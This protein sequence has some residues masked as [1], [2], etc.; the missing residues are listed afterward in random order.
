M[1]TWRMANEHSQTQEALRWIARWRCM[2]REAR[3][4]VGPHFFEE[5]IWSLA[6]FH[7]CSPRTTACSPPDICSGRDV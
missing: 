5:L 6:A 7:S 3:G 1:G 2:G 4:S